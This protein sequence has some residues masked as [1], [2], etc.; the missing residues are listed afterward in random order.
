MATGTLTSLSGV[1]QIVVE[2]YDVLIDSIAKSSYKIQTEQLTKA[3]DTYKYVPLGVI[4]YLVNNGEGGT[5]SSL[6]KPYRIYVDNYQDNNGDAEFTLEI[7]LRNTS[8][9]SAVADIV[10]STYVL[11]AALSA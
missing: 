5:G 3:A 7:G 9:S 11:F 6:I 10:I 8:T 2:Q 1:R 4:G